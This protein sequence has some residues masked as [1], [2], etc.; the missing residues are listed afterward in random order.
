MAGTQPQLLELG[1]GADKRRIAYL[2]EGSAGGGKPGLVWLC[3][4]KSEMTSTKATAV[5]DCANDTSAGSEPAE[6]AA[7]RPNGED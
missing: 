2:R 4:L 7:P 1:T 6:R 5:A 3:G